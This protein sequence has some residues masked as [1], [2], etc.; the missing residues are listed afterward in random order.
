MPE[1]LLF[2]T[3]ASHGW[4]IQGS[5]SP[6]QRGLVE[7]DRRVAHER[8]GLPRLARDRRGVLEHARHLH[9]LA[10]LLAE[11]AGSPAELRRWPREFDRGIDEGS[12][13]DGRGA[14]PINQA[15]LFINDYDHLS[16]GEK[17]PYG[18]E[19]V[20]KPVR[21]GDRSVKFS[22][23]LKKGPM[24]L[25]TWFRGQDIILSAYYVYVTRK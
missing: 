1:T 8:A 4:S 19:G 3:H 22:L 17:R 11:G 23:S 7:G 10:H 13:D 6:L 15:S 21:Q 18:F 20:T 9:A 2:D 25:H 24:A 14:L 5:R 16:I 12:T